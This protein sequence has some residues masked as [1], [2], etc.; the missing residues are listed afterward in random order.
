MHEEKNILIVDDSRIEQ[1]MLKASLEKDGFNVYAA[2]S[3]SEGFSLAGKVHIDIILVDFY[4]AGINDGTALVKKLRRYGL[5]VKIYAISSSHES[6]RELLDAG[7]DG[8]ISKDPGDIKKF[9]ND[10][11]KVD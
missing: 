6:S 11:I 9:L 7:C 10:S 3:V 5:H 2:S 4:L 1:K 8:I